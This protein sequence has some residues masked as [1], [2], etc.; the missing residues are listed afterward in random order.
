MLRIQNAGNSNF[1]A[2][3]AVLRKRFSR[4]YLVDLN[5]T[6]MRALDDSSIPNGGS[7]QDPDNLRGDYGLADFH[8]AHVFSASWVWE[9]PRLSGAPAPARLA[10]GGWELSGLVRLASGNPFNILSGRDNSL[11]AVNN[12]RPDVIGDPALP[13]D[14]PRA[15]LIAQYF[16]TAAFRA[17]AAGFFGNLG[18]NVLIGPGLANVD[19]GLFKSIPIWKESH[20]LQFRSEFFNLFNRPNFGSPTNNLVSPSFGRILSAQPARQIQL[21]LKYVF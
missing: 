10:L 17:N 8:R 3:A 11:R 19:A 16:S 2:L 20:R 12:D 4:G 15:E 6:W 9:L 5:Y 21:A 13:A 14:R 7:Y 1:N 18:R